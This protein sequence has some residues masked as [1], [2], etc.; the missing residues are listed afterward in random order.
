M[1]KELD[2]A[3]EAYGKSGGRFTAGILDNRYEDSKRDFISGALWAEKHSAYGKLKDELTEAKAN[4]VDMENEAKFMIASLRGQLG[5]AEDTIRSHLRE[6]ERL[7][8][9]QDNRSEEFTEA[10][11]KEIGHLAL[12]EGQAEEIERLKSGFKY[13]MLATAK[14][15]IQSRDALL[16]LCERA[17][18]QSNTSESQ[19]TASDKQVLEV[20]N[21][22]AKFKAGK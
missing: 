6:I 9:E 11:A 20:L 8:T 1:S 7:K 21:E 19:S 5:S 4:L 18:K 13:Q 12:I 15:E 22:I 17:L 14:K 3:A 16:L 10:R 2:E